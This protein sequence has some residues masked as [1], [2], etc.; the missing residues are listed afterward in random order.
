MKN[1]KIIV[2]TNSK[3][4][5]IYLGNKILNTAG[6][7]IRKNLPNVKKICIICDKKLPPIF[8]KMQPFKF[9]GTFTPLFFVYII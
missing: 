5:P 4:Y 6:T 2:K 1:S 7:L 3:I 8:L 9:G